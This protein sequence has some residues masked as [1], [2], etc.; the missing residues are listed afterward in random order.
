MAW[1]AALWLVEGLNGTELDSCHSPLG[2]CCTAVARRD[3]DLG[4]GDD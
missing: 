1:V 4:G 3:G 2:G